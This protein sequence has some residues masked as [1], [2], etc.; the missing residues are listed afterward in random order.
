MKI[1]VKKKPSKNVKKDNT[2]I[3]RLKNVTNVMLIVFHVLDQTTQTVQTVEPDSSL[4]QV[5]TEMLHARNVVLSVPPVL[6]PPKTIVNH[7]TQTIV[8]S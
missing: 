4:P 5:E 8:E 2:E 7:V 6:E 1:L 3:K